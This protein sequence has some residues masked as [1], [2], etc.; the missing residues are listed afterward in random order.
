[1]TGPNLRFYFLVFFSRFVKA[2]VPKLGPGGPLCMLLL[3]PTTIEIPGAALQKILR[4]KVPPNSLIQ[5]KLN[6]CVSP[7]FRTPKF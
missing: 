6:G 3:V 2:A 7:N 1:M 5:D 4:L